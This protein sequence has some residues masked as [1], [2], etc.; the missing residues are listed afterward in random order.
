M[1]LTRYQKNREILIKKALEY[2]YKNKEKCL[3]NKKKY[4]IKYHEKISEARRKKYKQDK[5]I[6][7]LKVYGISMADYGLILN[8][9]NGVCAI[10]GKTDIRSLGVDHC[11]KTKKVRGLLCYNCNLALGYFKDNVESL[12]KAIAYLKGNS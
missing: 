5:N 11:H 10:C 1:D 12:I 4:R 9:Q 7:Y 6:R 8:K 2:Y 3:L